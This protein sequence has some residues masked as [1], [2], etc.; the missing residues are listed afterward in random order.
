M[1]S[2]EELIKQYFYDG[3]TYKEMVNFLEIHEIKLSER[4]LQRKLKILGL[5]RKNIIEDEEIICRIIVHE[6]TGSGR[7]MGYKSMWRKIKQLYKENAYRDTV[8]KIM[9]AAD[10][11]GMAKRSRRVLKR[12]QYVTRGPN[13]LWHLGNLHFFN[14]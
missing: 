1:M 9:H 8:L 13:D 6:L 5:K 3:Y 7:C 11:E 12:R 4:H 2:E 10:P 14:I